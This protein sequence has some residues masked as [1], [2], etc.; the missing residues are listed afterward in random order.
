[1]EKRV[2]GF[3]A[4]LKELSWQGITPVE[5]LQNFYVTFAWKVY[6]IVSSDYICVMITVWLDINNI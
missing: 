1:M 4:E 6:Y 5:V 3:G 2:V